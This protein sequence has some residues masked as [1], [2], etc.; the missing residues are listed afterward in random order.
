MHATTMISW[1]DAT[2]IRPY[3]NLLSDARDHL[4]LMGI[5]SDGSQHTFHGA[6]KRE[7]APRTS[8]LIPACCFGDLGFGLRLEDQ[9]TAS[10]KPRPKA[11]FNLFPRG[12]PGRITSMLRKSPINLLLLFGGQRRHVFGS[13]TIP[14]ILRELETLGGTQLHQLR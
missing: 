13:N 4:I 11:R 9:P 12:G 6:K 5:P 7:T 3:G 10:S 8:S 1:S 2:Y 14:E